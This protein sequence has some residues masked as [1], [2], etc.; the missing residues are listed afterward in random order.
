MAPQMAWGPPMASGQDPAL[1]PGHRVVE[2][3]RLVDDRWPGERHEVVREVPYEVIREVPRE[4]PIE[5]MREMRGERGDRDVPYWQ[6][7]DF[8]RQL[9]DRK[10]ERRDRESRDSRDNT[11]GKGGSRDFGGGKGRG[12]GKGKGK[13]GG[14]GGKGGGKPRSKDDLDDDLDSYFSGKDAPEAT[15]S[16]KEA[17]SKGNL[18]DDLD[19]YFAAKSAPAAEE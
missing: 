5:V 15:R 17:A 14:K 10:A 8:E 4:V 16:R 2:P 11:R 9:D 6:R 7:D 3:V 13:G 19:S 12:G 18:D 1:P